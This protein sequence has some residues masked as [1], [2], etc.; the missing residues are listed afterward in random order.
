MVELKSGKQLIDINVRKYKTSNIYY[1]KLFTFELFIYC[2]SW[3]CAKHLKLATIHKQLNIQTLEGKK[4][5]DLA[6]WQQKYWCRD[7]V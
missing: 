1:E 5:I 6:L 3:W 7:N 4:I 2:E